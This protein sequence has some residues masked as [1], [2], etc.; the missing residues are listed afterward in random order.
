MSEDA[1]PDSPGDPGGEICVRFADARDLEF[2]GQ[3]G[4]IPAEVLARKVRWREVVVA[5]RD[6]EAVGYARLEYLWSTVPYLALIYVRPEHR[7][8]GVG[9]AMLEFLAERLR[10]QGHAGLYSSSQADEAAPQAWHRH[11]GF[12][13]CG[14]IA[15]INRGGVG[16]VF[17]RRRLL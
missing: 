11:V 14:F 2:V 8:R 4:Y 5:E 17:F 15:G 9:K 16:E 10:C 6:G 3:D 7:R 12:E 13:E 1:R